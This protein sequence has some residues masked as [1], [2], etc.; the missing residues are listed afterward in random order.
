LFYGIP[1]IDFIDYIQ[2]ENMPENKTASRFVVRHQ[3]P[4]KIVFSV[5]IVEA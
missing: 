3:K 5:V 1:Q 4:R 2:R